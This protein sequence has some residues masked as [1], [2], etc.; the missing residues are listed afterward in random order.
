[1]IQREGTRPV[2]RS[3]LKSFW[4]AIR[5]KE[6]PEG[7]GAAL[8]EMKLISEICAEIAGMR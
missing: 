7:G 5:I 2:L 3:S 8:L 1:M 6:R 4:T